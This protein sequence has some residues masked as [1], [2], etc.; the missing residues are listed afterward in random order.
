M[1]QDKLLVERIRN[2]DQHALE[3]LFRKYYYPL[4]QFAGSFVKS[5]DIAEEVVSDVFFNI[6]QNRNVL[7]IRNNLK[8]YLF[9]AI[10]NQSLNVLKKNRISFF[11][12]EIS[13]SQQK[14]SGLTAESALDYA[15][16]E[17]RIETIIE[18]LPPQRRIIFKLNRLEGFK[19]KEIADILQ[20][21]VNTVQKQMIEA[22]RYI[23]QYESQFFVSLVFGAFTLSSVLTRLHLII[24]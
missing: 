6:W 2:N 19:Y 7:D 13:E 5:P 4:C 3:Q 9:I 21:S 15:E 24:P 20:I 12:M 14:V 23:S 16:V 1:E 18:E 17:K 22:I 10:K 11:D 8:S